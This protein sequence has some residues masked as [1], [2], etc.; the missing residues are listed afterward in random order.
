MEMFRLDGR[1]ALVTGAA[2]GIGAA[3]A[4]ALHGAGA[5]VV[6][7][8]RDGDRLREL[9]SQAPGLAIEVAD[10]ALLEEVARLGTNVSGDGA[11]DILVLCA[12]VQRRR[13]WAEA[14]VEEAGA[15]LAVNFEASRALLGRLAPAM[16]KRGWG[17]ILAI[18]SVQELAPRPDMLVYAALKAAQTNLVMGLAKELAPHGVTC[19]VLAP[20]VI[21]TSRNTNALQDGTYRQ[22]VL[23]MIPAGRIGAPQDCTGTA[24]LLC[25]EAGAYITGQRFVVD[26]GMT[27]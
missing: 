3:I 25:S 13:P 21:E 17:R 9:Q 16:V 5:Q 15:E 6:A 22:Q 7:H 20:G 24:L 27:A 2:Q 12:S 18:G 10:L 1:R 11:V 8:D 23:S 19:N 4:V 14:L 26:G